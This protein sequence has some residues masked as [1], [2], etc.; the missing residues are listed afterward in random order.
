MRAKRMAAACQDFESRRDQAQLAAAKSFL[1]HQN[2]RACNEQLRP[3]I[4]RNPKLREAHLLLLESLAADERWD[5]ACKRGGQVLAAFPEDADALHAVAVVYDAAGHE[6]DALACFDRAARAEGTAPA[7]IDR[8]TQAHRT[9]RVSQSIGRSAKKASLAMPEP[10]SEEASGD[11]L[12]AELSVA[13]GDENE[14]AERVGALQQRHPDADAVNELAARVGV[15]AMP[16]PPPDV[17]ETAP[18]SNQAPARGDSSD[19]RHSGASSRRQARRPDEPRILRLSADGP[20]DRTPAESNAPGRLNTNARPLLPT[21]HIAAKPETAGRLLALATKA[22]A[23]D[24]VT[25]AEKYLTRLIDQTDTTEAEAIDAAV[26]PLRHEQPELSAQLCA[27]ARERWP[28]AVRLLEIEGTAQYRLKRYQEA[29][30]ALER[31]VALDEARATTHFLLG[32]TLRQ[33]GEDDAAQEHLQRA[34][35]LDR[36]FATQP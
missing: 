26:L 8:V 5:E 4:E 17:P 29:R 2:Y 33:L 31:A 35:Q 34:R 15:D 23:S 11:L 22:L 9:R 20:S 25:T 27:A 12:K 3:L 6:K 19:S 10:P 21:D 1:D 14:G 36:R 30:G 13:L 32:A 18:V 16:V 24:N 7:P 28:R